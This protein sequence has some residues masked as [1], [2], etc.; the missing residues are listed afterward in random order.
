MDCWVKWYLCFRSLWNHHTVF[1][2]SWTNFHSHQ[3]CISIPLSW[4]PCQHVLFLDFLIIAILTDVRHY[5]IN[6]SFTLSLLHEVKL[7]QKRR[8]TVA[9]FLDVSAFSQIREAPKSLLSTSVK[10]QT[11]L[12]QNNLHINSGGLSASS[13][14]STKYYAWRIVSTQQVFIGIWINEAVEKLL[15]WPIIQCGC[16]SQ[17]EV[18]ACVVGDMKGRLLL[19]MSKP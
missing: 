4:Q 10:S 15:R 6:G 11:S 13:Y 9:S 7:P 5:L 8:F 12:V 3:Q 16:L 19:S 14:P 18:C 1:H 2:N 17:V